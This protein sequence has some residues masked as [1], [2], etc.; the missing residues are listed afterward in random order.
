MPPLVSSDS[1]VSDDMRRNRTSDAATGVP[2]PVTNGGAPSD[3]SIPSARRSARQRS[4]SGPVSSPSVVAGSDS[5]RLCR[6]HQRLA[7][8]QPRRV[9]RSPAVSPGNA[10]EKPSPPLTAP[11][12]SAP[13]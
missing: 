1:A 10:S 13:V 3:A 6:A 9:S 12:I 4:A 11:L 5:S 7:L 2:S 8:E